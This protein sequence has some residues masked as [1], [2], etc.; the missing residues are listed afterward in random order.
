M[1]LALVMKNSSVNTDKYFNI[2]K[3]G[4]VLKILLALNF[5]KSNKICIFSFNAPYTTEDVSEAHEYSRR[6]GTGLT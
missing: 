3:K 4:F 5:P 1:H 6:V 2:A